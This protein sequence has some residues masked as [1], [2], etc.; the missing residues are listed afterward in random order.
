VYCHRRA[1]TRSA[2]FFL[3]P[4][5]ALLGPPSSRNKQHFSLTPELSSPSHLRAPRGL[6]GPS[7]FFCTPLAKYLAL[8]SFEPSLCS[9]SCYI[10]HCSVPVTGGFPRSF[11]YVPPPLT[12]P[13]LPVVT[14]PRLLEHRY[15]PPRV[16]SPFP[17]RPLGGLETRPVFI[18][19]YRFPVPSSLRSKVSCIPIIFFFF[20]PPA[21]DFPRMRGRFS[22]LGSYRPSTLSFRS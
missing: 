6:E 7:I 20:P 13:P 19:L 4:S 17:V 16:G 15:A 9:L 10:N 8:V 1:C 22:F 3:I 14:V 18:F 2:T 21:S 12:I 5:F 11:F